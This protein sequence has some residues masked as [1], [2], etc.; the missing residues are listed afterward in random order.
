M[1]TSAT[2]L[3]L[4]ILQQFYKL[5][6]LKSVAIDELKKKNYFYLKFKIL[7][8]DSQTRLRFF[9]NIKKKKNVW[10]FI[11]SANN[12]KNER[13]FKR[14]RKNKFNELP[15]KKKYVYKICI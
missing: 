13:N 7:T 15:K 12:R 6:K 1:W 5:K 8:K 4:K 9:A 14:A 2:I 11:Y 3:S 10:E